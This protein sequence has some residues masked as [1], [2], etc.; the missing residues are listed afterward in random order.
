MFWRAQQ[1]SDRNLALGVWWVRHKNVSH[2]NHSMSATILRTCYASTESLGLSELNETYIIPFGAPGSISWAVESTIIKFT[3]PHIMAPEFASQ[4]C[5][6]HGQRQREC[7]KLGIAVSMHRNTGEC[8]IRFAVTS[9]NKIE[10][11]SMEMLSVQLLSQPSKETLMSCENQSIKAFDMPTW[12]FAFLLSEIA[13][14]MQLITW[15]N[16]TSKANPK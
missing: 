15:R 2:P 6:T 9:T 8:L 13:M 1:G 14:Q 12:E 7:L 10:F 3:L 5:R 16:L 4:K 11:C